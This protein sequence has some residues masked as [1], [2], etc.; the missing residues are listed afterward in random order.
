MGITPR[1]VNS[2]SCRPE[3]GKKILQ[4]DSY[5]IH[6]HSHTHFILT[7]LQTLFLKGKYTF[8][9]LLPVLHL[10]SFLYMRTCYIAAKQTRTNTHPQDSLCTVT[11][12]KLHADQTGRSILEWK[13]F[14]LQNNIAE[15][16]KP[17]NFIVQ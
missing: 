15:N 13:K 11:T 3:K 6:M 9:I 14:P 16:P 8:F 17:C 7:K 1:T 10:F 12:D 4:D 5:F 2:F